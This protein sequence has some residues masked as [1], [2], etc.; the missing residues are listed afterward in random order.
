MSSLKA[1]ALGLDNDMPPDVQV[2]ESENFA[3]IDF[4]WSALGRSGDAGEATETLYE[5]AKNKEHMKKLTDDFARNLAKKHNLRIPI[6]ST[7]G[8]WSEEYFLKKFLEKYFC[9]EKGSMWEKYL[10]G[11][12]IGEKTKYG[13]ILYLQTAWNQII[14]E[15]MGAAPSELTFVMGHTHKPFERYLSSEEVGIPGLDSDVSVYN[16]GGWMV[17]EAHCNPKKGG[18]VFLLDKNL[19]HAS[20]CMY[21][22]SEEGKASAKRKVE[23]TSRKRKDNKFY[24]KIKSMVEENEDSLCCLSNLIDY[25]LEVR[26][27]DMKCRLQGL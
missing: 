20:I 2:L 22:E 6:V 24:E 18:S 1:S 10:E 12:E 5:H 14:E 19:N 9:G 3:W 21:H 27:E 25:E 23:V 7:L 15:E 16:T 8:D 13:L 11:E 26:K 4:F 17:D